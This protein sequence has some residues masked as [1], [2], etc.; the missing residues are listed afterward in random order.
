MPDFVPIVPSV[1][2]YQMTQPF[3]FVIGQEYNRNADIHGVYKGQARGGISTPKG[4]PFVFIVNSN[5][6]IQH[7]YHDEFRD[8][9]QFWYTDEGLA[10]DMGMA[11]GNKA[12]SHH[13]E[14][15]PNKHGTK[16]LVYIFHLDIDFIPSEEQ[17][18][19]NIETL[20]GCDLKYLSKKPY[21]ECSGIVNLAT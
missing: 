9:G 1:S 13:E 14:L 19:T 2:K 17:I 7:G 20:T 18:D 16:S 15:R 5:T 8:D 11:S 6:G 3:P 21:D 12:I 4:Y 10:G